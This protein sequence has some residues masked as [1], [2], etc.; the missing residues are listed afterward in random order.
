MNISDA[1]YEYAKSEIVPV[2]ARGSDFA[3]GLV[4]GI[5]RA[6]K[7]KISVKFSDNSML[8]SIGIVNEDGS[9]DAE[10]LREFIEGV[11]DGRTEMPI[12]LADLLKATTGITSDNEL[13][14]DRIKITRADAEK[15]L[16]LIMR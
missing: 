9:V 10:T 1:L 5:L 8:R 6:G 4:N 11:F 2:I 14:Q 3:A 12:T 15:L 13:L 7:K 16:E